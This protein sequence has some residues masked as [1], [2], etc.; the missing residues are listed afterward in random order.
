MGSNPIRVMHLPSLSI[1]S[2]ILKYFMTI[3][4]FLRIVIQQFVFELS[5][6]IFG[7][8]FLIKGEDVVE[9]YGRKL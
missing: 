2:L 4:I 5:R 3:N 8:Q 6:Y 7:E 1:I 9:I